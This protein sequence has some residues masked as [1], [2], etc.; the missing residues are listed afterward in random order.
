MEPVR[1]RVPL[2]MLPWGDEQQESGRPEVQRS[3]F[4]RSVMNS[5]S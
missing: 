4:R 2:L 1:G 5:A 3:C